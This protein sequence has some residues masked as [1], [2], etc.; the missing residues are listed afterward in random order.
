M[1]HSRGV[2]R[3]YSES[4]TA[5]TTARNRG[6]RP[7]ESDDTLN[8]TMRVLDAEDGRIH[9]ARH[10]RQPHR[11]VGF[12]HQ[13]MNKVRAE[14]IKKWALTV[15]IL[16]V[17]IIAVLSMYWAVLF[18]VQDN[19]RSL[20][21]QVVDFDGQV[22]PY[23]NVE[24]FIGP[25]VTELVQQSIDQVDAPTIG[26]EIVPVRRFDW[27]P[28]AVRQSVYDFHSYAAIIVNPN[29]TALLME[30]IATG[31][32]TYDPTGAIQMI[33][34]SA[35]SESTYYNYIIPQLQAFTDKLMAQF[36]PA[37]TQRLAGNDSVTKQ[38]LS[39][40]PAAVNPGIS[41]LMIDLRPFQPAAATPSVSIGL[42]YLIIM[43]FFSF[44]FFLPIHMKYIQPAGHPPLHYWQFIVWRWVAT[45]ACYFLI[46][47]AYSLVSLAFQIPF[48]TPPAS[49]V[50]VAFGATAYGRGSFPVYWMINFVGMIALGLACENVAM[51]VG[52]PWT[53]LWLIFWVIS[54]VSTGFYSLD[55]APGFFKWGYAWPLHNIVE[56]SRS[57][58]F[59]L[60]SRIGLNFGIL[61]AWCA[62]NTILFPLCCYFMRW[63]M[64]HGQRQSQKA[65][66]RYSV[67]TNDGEL[68]FAK[69]QGQLPPIRKRGFMRG[70]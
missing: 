2:S 52:Q 69:E 46:S 22:A 38:M 63:K 29:A 40:A 35:R 10:Y 4:T 14:V 27:D 6:P 32:S 34:V 41:P 28:I 56:A 59:D 8:D 30:A 17:F 53:A 57:L 12:W 21:V 70:I 55:L 23:D 47:L 49:P 66:D 54:N 64:E 18:R 65:K 58:L 5:S 24:P 43:A 42:I 25:M 19:M 44:S 3:S 15:L 60:H 45:V 33:L 31:N 67:D 1:A 68:E 61:F 9:S 48:W 11:S 20:T 51:I 39:A 37:W 26:Y 36:G 50:D 13:G 7:R 16:I 62:V